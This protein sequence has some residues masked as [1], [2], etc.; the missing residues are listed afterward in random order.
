[1]MDSRMRRLILL[2]SLSVFIAACGFGSRGRKDDPAAT[3]AAVRSA[4][5]AYVGAINANKVDAWLDALS[6]D[7]VYLVPNQ[8]AIVGK[9]AVA[10]WATR[11]LQEVTTKWSKPVDDIV[12]SGDWAFGRY[13]YTAAD[14]VIIHDPET[15]GGGTANDSG[16]G[17]IVYHREGGGRW[18]VARDAW[19]SDRP[20]H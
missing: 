13:A 9:A 4:H 6:D 5:E 19:G 15:E 1:M 3:L 8:K 18:R 10:A 12:V 20:A 16:W 11:Y 2:L 17:L 7:V 14:S